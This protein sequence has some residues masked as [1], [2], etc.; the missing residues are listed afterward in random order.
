MKEQVTLDIE[1]PCGSPTAGR[2]RN[3]RSY[4]WCES[5]MMSEGRAGPLRVAT[6]GTGYVVLT[7]AVA[8]AYLG[9]RVVSVGTVLAE[10]AGNLAGSPSSPSLEFVRTAWERRR[11][12]RR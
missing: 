1:E 8:L 3:L 4:G 5:I 2:R 12:Y 11:P 10:P 6:V 7:A 9:H